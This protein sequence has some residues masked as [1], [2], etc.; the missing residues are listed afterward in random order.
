MPGQE[1]ET[2]SH[3]SQHEESVQVEEQTIEDRLDTVINNLLSRFTL[4][5]GIK[6]SNQWRKT[7]KNRDSIDLDTLT[8][9]ETD[10]KAFT[11][12]LLN[13]GTLDINF[14]QDS[15]FVEVGSGLGKIVIASAVIRMF[16]KVIGIEIVGPLYR[17]AME[18]STVFSKNFRNPLEQC[19][20][21]FVNAD[22]TYV[23]W[24]YANLVYI[25]ATSFDQDMMVRVDV[26]AQKMLISSVIMIMNNRLLREQYF[27][28]V[29]VVEI[30]QSYG[31]SQLFVYRKMLK[32]DPPHVIAEQ[33]L[34]QV[35]AK[36]YSLI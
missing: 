9:A 32:G 11:T 13:I 3:Q 36:T 14:S 20:I 31:T 30:K 35:L 8:Y 5:D 22:G 6:I 24:S 1:D 15:V 18:L 23:D 16:R 25:D 33:K 27:E 17:K 2:Q 26:T 34:K 21:E 28:L 7:L 29:K 4:G 19:D 10:V 12:F